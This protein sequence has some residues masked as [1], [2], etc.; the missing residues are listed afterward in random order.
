MLPHVARKDFA[1]MIRLR[2]LRWVDYPGLS[3]W[4]FKAITYTHLGEGGSGRY[5]DQRLEPQAMESGSSPKLEEQ[6]R[7]YSLE[8]QGVACDNTLTL[9]Q[10]N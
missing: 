8:L 4:T 7:D 2:I 6:G 3:G 10:R 5:E 1:D 9:A